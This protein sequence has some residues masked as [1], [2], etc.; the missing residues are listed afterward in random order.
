MHRTKQWLSGKQVIDCSENTEL[1][2]INQRDRRKNQF[3][4]P[5]RT[6][7]RSKWDLL[8]YL[9]AWLDIIISVTID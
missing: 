8:V 9:S 1:I 7:E 3:D 4:I 6:S 2:E 5:K